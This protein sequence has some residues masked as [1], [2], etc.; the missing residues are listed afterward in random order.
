[1]GAGYQIVLRERV[2]CRNT[3][4]NFTRTH[5][6]SCSQAQQIHTNFILCLILLDTD[7]FCSTV[8]KGKQAKNLENAR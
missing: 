7:H 3:S 4:T 1:M 5:S 2:A 8:L 6:G